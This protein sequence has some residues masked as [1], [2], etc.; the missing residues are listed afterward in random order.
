[1]DA[2]CMD[3]FYCIDM[4]VYWRALTLDP[5][6]CPSLGMVPN[7]ASRRFYGPLRLWLR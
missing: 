4:G 5:C 1:M 6:R 7:F 3:A 2:L